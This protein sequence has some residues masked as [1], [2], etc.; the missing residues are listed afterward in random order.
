M[1]P[2]T[3]LCQVE[4][5]H[6]GLVWAALPLELEVLLRGICLSGSPTGHQTHT[7][8]ARHHLPLK[9]RRLLHRR[10]RNRGDTM[11]TMVKPP[12]TAR[13]TL[14]SHPLLQT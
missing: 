8:E 1:K 9:C 4:K 11:V 2:R 7:V 3:W 14:I 10:L 13:L 5:H 6:M 12:T